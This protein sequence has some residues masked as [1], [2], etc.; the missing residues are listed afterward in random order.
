MC[1]V[2]NIADRLPVGPCHGDVLFNGI[3]WEITTRLQ[4]IIKT[5]ASST[6]IPII[7]KIPRS[8]MIGTCSTCNITRYTS[9]SPEGD[10]LSCTTKVRKAERKYK[11]C[12]PAGR[13]SREHRGSPLRLFVGQEKS[14]I[15]DHR[16]FALHPSLLT[17]LKGIL[18]VDCLAA[19]FPTSSA[20]SAR[21]RA[22][23][24][25]AFG[26]LG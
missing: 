8:M 21:F 23:V 25:L 10:N 15:T 3:I 9:M 26:R 12:A 16:Q 22:A 18:D 13:P 4:V 7:T 1:R 5:N 14:P 11:R 24:N 17:H 20:L 2:T 6:P 19:R